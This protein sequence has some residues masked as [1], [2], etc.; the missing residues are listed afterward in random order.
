MKYKVNYII[1]SREREAEVAE[2]TSTGRLSHSDEFITF[3]T[4]AQN[5]KILVGTKVVDH[6]INTPAK[7]V[8]T[9]VSDGTS[10]GKPVSTASTEKTTV[11]LDHVMTNAVT[12]SIARHYREGSQLV[13][14]PTKSEGT[15]PNTGD[16]VNLLLAL[17]GAALLGL[18]GA[19]FKKREEK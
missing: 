18:T 16:N 1:F 2:L 10:A 3:E 11:A 7:P 19:G 4:P 5:G 14:T 13:E 17:S 6:T 12:Q 8:D 15:L 9:V